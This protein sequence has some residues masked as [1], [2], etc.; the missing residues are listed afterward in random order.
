[1]NKFEKILLTIFFIELFVGGGGRLIDFRVVSIR[2]ILFLLLMVTF[3]VRII[4]NKA[5]FNKE[6]NTF[7]RFTPIAIGIYLMVAWFVVSCLIGI[8]HHHPLGAIATDFFRVVFIIA[9]FPLAYYISKDRFP[10]EKIIV[11][12]KRSALAVAIFTIAVDL[13]GKT[14]FASNFGDF[15]N[16]MNWMMNDD[17]FFRPSNSVF[18]KSHFFVLVGVVLSLNDLL[19]KKFTKMDLTLIILGAISLIWSETRGFLLA[20]IL[21][22]LM[23]IIL[24]IKVIVD[25]IKGLAQKVQSLIKTKK[26][27]KKFIILLVII[28]AV[29][30]LY[31]YMTLSRFQTVNVEDTTSAKYKAKIHRQVNDESVNK[32]MEFIA[33]S[34]KILSHPAN[35]IV[36]TGYGTT[37]AG[38]ITGIEMSFL[39]IL[40]EQGLIGLGTW[41]FLFLMVY[42]NFYTAYKKERKLSTLDISLMAAFMGVLLLT[43]INPFINNPIGICFFLIVLVASQNIKHQSLKGNVK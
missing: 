40:V 26:F 30:N 36:G 37:I 8:L 5:I 18:Y 28:I 21:C 24:D 33:D 1:M 20:F 3:V 14:I 6:M 38:R 16:F 7:I 22:L 27:V 2:Q 12:L 31:N 19:N 17:L 9:Y 11:L 23:I 13:L 41:C 42:L 34:K 15:Y 4:K 32:R 29:P 39:D 10:L 43:N 35:L 25:P